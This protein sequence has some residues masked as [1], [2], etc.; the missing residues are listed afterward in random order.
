[1]I[2][3]T[4]LTSPMTRGT[5]VASDKYARYLLHARLYLFDSLDQRRGQAFMNYLHMFDPDAY[6]LLP[7]ALNPFEREVVF[8][9]FLAYLKDAWTGS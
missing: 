4:A 6:E 5:P 1:M 9:D 3:T 2:M 8:H 7:E